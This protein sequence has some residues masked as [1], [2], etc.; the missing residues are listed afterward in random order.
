[1]SELTIRPIRLDERDSAYLLLHQLRER[2]GYE[3]FL[4][5]LERQQ[6]AG[7]QLLGAFTDRLVGLI[8]WRPVETMARGPHLHIDD[9]VVDEGLRQ[10]GIGK[11]LL[12]HAEAYAR[13][14]GYTAVFLDSRPAALGFYEKQ[15]YTPHTAPLV[16]KDIAG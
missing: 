3:E 14:L 5:R 4:A 16:R 11:A 6:R 2:L 8:G 12:D 10:Q 15:G 7:Y 1:M 13:A 9:L